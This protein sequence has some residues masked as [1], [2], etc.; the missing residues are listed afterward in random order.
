MQIVVNQNGVIE[1]YVSAGHSVAFN[2][3]FLDNQNKDN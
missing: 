3:Q 2:E 1:W